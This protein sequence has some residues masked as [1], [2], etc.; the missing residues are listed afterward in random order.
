MNKIEMMLERHK[1][2]IEALQSTC[3]HQEKSDWMMEMWNYGNTTGYEIRKCKECDKEIDRR[4]S[5]KMLVET[6]WAYLGHICAK[7]SGDKLDADDPCA[8]TK[9]SFQKG[10]KRDE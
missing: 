5:K 6:K 4:K 10:S 3:P 1:Q 2:E 7:L 9:L 8:N